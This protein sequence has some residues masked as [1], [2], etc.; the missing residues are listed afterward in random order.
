M[1]VGSAHILADVMAG[2]EPAIDLEGLTLDRYLG[3][4]AA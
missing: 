2:R 3:G 4:A 1:A